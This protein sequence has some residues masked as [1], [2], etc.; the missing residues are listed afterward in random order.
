M[1]QKHNYIAIFS[2]LLTIFFSFSLLDIKNTEVTSLR[3]GEL[4]EATI[5]SSSTQLSTPLII[6]GSAT[7]LNANNW[8]KAIQDGWVTGQGTSTDPYLIDAIEVDTANLGN[9]L[10]IQNSKNVYFVINNSEFNAGDDYS[11]LELVNTANGTITGSS[12]AGSKH[13]IFL[14]GGTMQNTI[15]QNKI[16]ENDYGI[17]FGFMSM[18]NMI[19]SNGISDN[20]IFGAFSEPSASNN[21]ISMNYFLRNPIHAKDNSSIGNM[22][23]LTM[24]GNFWDD[25]NGEDKDTNSIGDDPY[26]ITGEIKDFLPI[27]NHD[28]M[29][30]PIMNHSY[31]FESTENIVNWTVFDMISFD[32]FYEVYQ[33]GELI[34]SGDDWTPEEIVINIDGLEVGSYNFTLIVFDGLGGINSNQID[35]SVVNNNNMLYVFIGILV[36]FVGILLF[37]KIRKG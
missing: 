35:V 15:S 37:I 31:I 32:A 17:K 16:R 7:G 11:A 21:M 36:V 26:A 9:A 23:N 3:S 4:N 2:I 1:K 19:M 22:W 34:L 10:T 13:G 29:I 28:P 6:D 18:A 20:D 24:M 5:F 25:Y 8:T 14:N 30:M 12:F 27:F 33:N